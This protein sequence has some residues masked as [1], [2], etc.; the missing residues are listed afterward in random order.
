MTERMK[1]AMQERLLR[2]KEAAEYLGLGHSTLA[3]LRVSGGG[4][5][6]RK[7]GRS[8]RYTRED[9]QR[10]ADERSRRSTSDTMRPER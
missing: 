2:P 9:L 3:K 7:F 6:F 8:V 10:W 4:P 1:M 5:A